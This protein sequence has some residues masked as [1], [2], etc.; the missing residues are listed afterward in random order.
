MSEQNT[1]FRCGT[2]AIVGR[3]NVGKSTLLNRLVEAKL[4]ITSRKPQTT[5]Y[6]IRGIRSEQTAQYIFVDT[7]GFQRSHG[8]ALNQ[9]LNRTV[10]RALESVDVVMP[11]VAAGELNASDLA[12]VAVLPASTP[13]VVAVNKA[14]S[15][16][17]PEDML[18]FLARIQAALPAKAI[19][20]VSAKTGHNVEALLAT[21]RE[22]LPVQ[23][24]IFASDELT[25]RDERFL[26]AEI[27]REK[28]FRT[29]GQEVPY[30]STVLVDSFK[31]EGSLRRIHAT[32]IVSRAGHKPIILGP[33]GEG[34]KT[35]ATQSRLDMEALFG[36]KVHLEV[37]IKIRSGWSDD[38]AQLRRFGLE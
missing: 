21:V 28:L 23:P 19:V 37:W 36:G 26:A 20:P 29:L 4:S 14:D 30:G 10:R 3:P 35:I 13:R 16:R 9:S 2:V 1:I 38:V 15:L 27:I 18:P 31:L 25:D 33:K 12:V 32:I 5:R 17:R 7:P 24:A 34:I 11:V 22:L 8:G 6:E